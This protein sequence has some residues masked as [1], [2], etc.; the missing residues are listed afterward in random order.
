ME[1]IPDQDRR[2]VEEMSQRGM[3]VVKVSAEQEREWRQEAEAFIEL[4]ME[5][6][7]VKDLLELA[8][9]ERDAYRA[10]H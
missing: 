2:A 8:R 4:K 6:I 5:S 10:S 3:S 9:R 1:E 7:A